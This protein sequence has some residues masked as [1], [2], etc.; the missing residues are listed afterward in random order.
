LI[1]IVVLCLYV[2][3]VSGAQQIH[4]SSNPPMA[5]HADV[6]EQTELFVLPERPKH[7]V[8]AE[9]REPQKAVLPVIEIISP[10]QQIL[11]NT[12]VPEYKPIHTR[13]DATDEEILEANQQVEDELIKKLILQDQINRLKLRLYQL[14]H[15]LGVKPEHHDAAQEHHKPEPAAP[16]EHHD[17]A[18]EHKPEPAAPAEHHDTAQEHKPEP[19]APASHH[20]AAQEPHKP[21]SA[22][23]VS[24][25]DSAHDSDPTHGPSS[26]APFAASPVSATPA[27]TTQAP[28]TPAP[29][30][31]APATPNKPAVDEITV[32]AR[33]VEKVYEE[34]KSSE[35]FLSKLL[36]KN[37]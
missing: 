24:H 6:V 23:P 34:I 8:S 13:P 2:I 12:F 25:H 27:P 1:S 31:P 30:T 29:A 15:Q 21:D 28:A 37:H 33:E 16:A 26:N 32:D 17:A 4:I 11:Q 5:I 22:A 3:S 20:D 35:A 7:Y 18:Q 19:A 14:Q 36:G 9:I 10:E